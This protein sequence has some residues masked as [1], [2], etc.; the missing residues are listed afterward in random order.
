MECYPLMLEIE[1][2]VDTFLSHPSIQ[3]DFQK[4]NILSRFPKMKQR[5]QLSEKML[6]FYSAKPLALND[7]H[8]DTNNFYHWLYTVDNSFAKESSEIYWGRL[9]NYFDTFPSLITTDN[10]IWMCLR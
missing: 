2:R 3:N 10:L 8:S 1:Q 9:T 7:F 6:Q 5:E 4:L